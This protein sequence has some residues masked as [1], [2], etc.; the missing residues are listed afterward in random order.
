M[1]Q[2]IAKYASIPSSQSKITPEPPNQILPRLFL[3]CPP[4]LWPPKF[5]LP[6]QIFGWELELCIHESY[7]CYEPI[8]VNAHPVVWD[9]VLEVIAEKAVYSSLYQ[10][11]LKC[12]P[13][14]FFVGPVLPDTGDLARFSSISE[15]NA[16]EVGFRSW[17]CFSKPVVEAF[18]PMEIDSKL[19]CKNVVGS[20]VV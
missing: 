7:V 1:P 11:L 10:E 14:L 16:V 19:R 9:I 15:D 2:P 17:S 13:S 18:C 4:A 20:I 8:L 5:P 3:L 6:K 12:K